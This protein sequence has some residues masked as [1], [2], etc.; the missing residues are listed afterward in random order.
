MTFEFFSDIKDGK[1]QK[2]VRDL[3]SECLLSFN[4]K[5]VSIIIKPIKSKRSL[6]QNNYIH[7]LLTIFAKELTILT[8]EKYSM[9]TVK[10]MCKLNFAL[11]DIVNTNTGEV[12]GQSLEQTSKMSKSRC[13]DFTNDI[14]AWAANE[15]HITLPFPNEQVELNI[16]PE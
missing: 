1:T 2:N 10:D 14:I 7:L 6:N 15:F 11:I 13:A 8:G 9:E 16:G 5:R 3:I 4:N 12:I